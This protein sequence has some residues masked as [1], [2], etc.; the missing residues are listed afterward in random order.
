MRLSE[1]AARYMDFR[2]NAWS[3]ASVKT[4]AKALNRLLREVGDREVSDIGSDTIDHFLSSEAMRKVKPS[5]Y[6]LYFTNIRLFF[7]W[8]MVRG[9]TT[10][11]PFFGQR[12]KALPQQN[13]LRIPLEKFPTLINSAYRPRE[14]MI[15][16]LGLYLMLR[17]SEVR[18]IQ[19][20]HVNL[21]EG[22]VQVTIHKNRD[23]TIDRMPISPELDAELRTWLTHYARLHGRLD[24]EWYLIPQYSHANKYMPSDHEWDFVPGKG[25][26]PGMISRQVK[27]IIGTMG[28][29]SE[30]TGMHT[31]RRSA[32][33]ALFMEKKRLGYDGALR[34]VSSWLHHKN[35]RTSEIYLGMDID[36]NQR[37]KEAKEAPLFPS[38]Q[39]ENVVD[40]QKKGGV[41]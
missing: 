8:C 16:C 34:Q 29:D 2:A 28:Y 27:F 4:D 39:D 38:L 12:Q 20:K 21:S 10:V 37:D 32:A 40:I 18:S 9:Y 13:H 26:A 35:Q 17:E 7:K 41:A 19:L 11:D 33:A 1:A 6:N 3:E 24:D 15:V 30:G 22:W 31:L 23:K 14:R 36:R 25:L 5:T